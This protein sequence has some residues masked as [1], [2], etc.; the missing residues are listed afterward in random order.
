MISK[1]KEE[2][3]GPRQLFRTTNESIHLIVA[4]NYL[5]IIIIIIYTYT[6]MYIFRFIQIFRLLD[7]LV[8]SLIQ[9]RDSFARIC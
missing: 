8:R 3:F 1:G 7:L 4:S 2:N 5:L 6:G 9:S